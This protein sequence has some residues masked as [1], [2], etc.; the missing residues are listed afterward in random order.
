[1]NIL[2]PDDDLEKDQ[3][4]YWIILKLMNMISDTGALKK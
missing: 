4:M 1:M 2:P 3:N